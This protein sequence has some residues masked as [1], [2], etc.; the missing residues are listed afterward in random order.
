[1]QCSGRQYET[2]VL[3]CDMLD[4]ESSNNRC[5]EYSVILYIVIAVGVCN[6]HSC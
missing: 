2:V 5:F 4:E 6:V 3:F 1:M